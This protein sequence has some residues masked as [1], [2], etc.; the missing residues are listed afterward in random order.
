MATSEPF[1]F[2]K[3]RRPQFEGPLSR[4]RAAESDDEQMPPENLGDLLDQVSK[5]STVGIDSLIGELERLRGK[6]QMP[7]IDTKAVDAPR[8]YRASGSFVPTFIVADKTRRATRCQPTKPRKNIVP[9]YAPIL[10]S[11]FSA[12]SLS[13]TSQSRSSE[14]KVPG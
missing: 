7:T 14:S 2:A 3:Y 8:A 12:S 6:L 11:T 10:A 13:A 9:R 5:D 1:E 4:A